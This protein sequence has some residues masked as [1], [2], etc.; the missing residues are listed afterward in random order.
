MDERSETRFEFAA[1]VEEAEPDPE[2][3]IVVYR[4]AQEALLNCERHA[5]AKR[6]SLSVR[7]ENGGFAIEIADDGVGFDPDEASD[8]GSFG[9]LAMRERAAAV[10]GRLD[11]DAK[12]GAGARLTL[13]IPDAGNAP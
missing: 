4:I 7:R 3:K 9:L 12:P 1:N 8:G 2:A 13:V 6:A 10:G 11:V 5:R